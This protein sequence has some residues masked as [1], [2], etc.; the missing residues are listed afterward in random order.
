M[1]VV[2]TTTN[3]NIRNAHPLVEQLIAE[4]VLAAVEK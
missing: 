4:H 3:Y 1:D 2:I